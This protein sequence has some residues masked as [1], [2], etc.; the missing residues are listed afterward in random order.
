MDWLLYLTNVYLSYIILHG[1]YIFVMFMQL[2]LVKF[3]ASGFVRDKMYWLSI[4]CLF[5]LLL[6]KFN[7]L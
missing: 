6:P 2:A 1:I 4:H 7:L 5:W 3:H